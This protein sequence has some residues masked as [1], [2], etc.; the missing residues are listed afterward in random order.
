MEKSQ[1][2]GGMP[3]IK[4][5]TDVENSAILLAQD[6]LNHSCASDPIQMIS[7]GMNE[8]GLPASQTLL[9]E[10]FKLDIEPAASLHFQPLLSL[11]AQFQDLPIPVTCAVQQLVQG[12]ECQPQKE[13]LIE[14]MP[15]QDP[16]PTTSFST[17]QGQRKRLAETP[18]NES[19]PKRKR[20]LSTPP[21]KVSSINTLSTGCTYTI[22]SSPVPNRMSTGHFSAW[23]V[24]DDEVLYYMQKDTNDGQP[25]DIAFIPT[26]C[27]KAS[28]SSQ[29]FQNSRDNCENQ[30]NPAIQSNKKH[31]HPATWMKTNT[32]TN[33]KTLFYTHF[34]EKLLNT[35]DTS[36]QKETNDCDGK[37]PPNSPEIWICDT[38]SLSNKAPAVRCRGC[39]VLKYGVILQSCKRIQSNEM[40][41]NRRRSDNICRVE[42]DRITTPQVP[43]VTEMSPS[44]ATS[45]SSHMIDV[46]CSVPQMYP[47]A[48]SSPTSTEERMTMEFLPNGTVC[49]TVL[50]P[51]EINTTALLSSVP[52]GTKPDEILFHATSPPVK[53]TL[54]DVN[55][56]NNALDPGV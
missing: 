31:K 10:N 44:L 12:K 33:P 42:G 20:N 54:Q 2:G 22:K 7:Q 47:S 19:M 36:L 24:E 5:L 21:P 37:N 4:I 18:I 40:S 26:S 11:G 15:V 32:R 17:N 41:T 46:I 25:E 45:S 1:T 55:K 51:T 27:Q 49:A 53:P 8:M 35:P 38:C 30:K 6:D 52:A 56:E 9:P 23:G 50:Q 14:E 13:V 39:D 29:S 3:D 43:G 28:K 16:T 34:S 48:G